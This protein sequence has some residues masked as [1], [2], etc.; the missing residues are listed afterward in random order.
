[1]KFALLAITLSLAL[2]VSSQTVNYPNKSSKQETKFTD[3]P[4]DVWVHLAPF[5]DFPDLVRFGATT[6]TNSLFKPIIEK[7]KNENLLSLYKYCGSK[8]FH[9]MMGNSHFIFERN[10][11]DVRVTYH[12]ASEFLSTSTKCIDAITNNLH[13]LKKRFTSLSIHIPHISQNQEIIQATSNY[14]VS[15]NRLFDS[16]G[17]IREVKL[18]VINLP[19]LLKEIGSP[20]EIKLYALLSKIRMD[21]LEVFYTIKH[22]KAFKKFASASTIQSLLIN[23]DTDTF[24]M[25]SYFQNLT[26][27]SVPHD[28]SDRVIKSLANVKTL[29]NITG[30]KKLMESILIGKNVMTGFTLFNEPAPLSSI[31]HSQKKFTRLV[32]G[33]DENSDIYHTRIVLSNNKA[34]LT[35]FSTLISPLHVLEWSTLLFDFLNNNHVIKS[36]AIKTIQKEVYHYIPANIGLSCLEHA[37][38]LESFTY[39]GYLSDE[40]VLSPLFK[41]IKTHSTLQIIYIRIPGVMYIITEDRFMFFFQ[42]LVNALLVRSNGL[43]VVLDM[44]VG[45]ENEN[46]YDLMEWMS[47][48][49]EILQGRGIFL[50]G[51]SIEKFVRDIDRINPDRLIFK[52]ERLLMIGESR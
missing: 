32:F 41:F 13:L 22:F 31:S 30:S 46:R 16:I 1:M 28:P 52:N 7:T 44:N 51:I 24:Y 3:V 2:Q 38:E 48:R 40:I 26:S 17:Y 39:E 34:S 36:L 50:N 19:G 25:I 14:F 15:L 11:E 21:N 6:K 10:F 20:N 8:A 43:R 4:V 42:G 49:V 35:H 29:I 12:N 5:L 18:H 23:L 47:A 9:K 33:D 37:E 45:C 27:I